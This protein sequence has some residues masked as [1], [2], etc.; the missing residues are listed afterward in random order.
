MSIMHGNLTDQKKSLKMGI[1]W[2]DLHGENIPH[3]R[4]DIHKKNSGSAGW[5]FENLAISITVGAAGS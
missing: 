3:N 5:S 1:V 4:P 2:I